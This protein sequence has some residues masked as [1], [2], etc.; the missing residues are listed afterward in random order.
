MRMRRW[1]TRRGDKG[2]KITSRHTH[3]HT[4]QYSTATEPQSIHTCGR[5]LVRLGRAVS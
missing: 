3:T 4:V 2:S 5:Y 1:E